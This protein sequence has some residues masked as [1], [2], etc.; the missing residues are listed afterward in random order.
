[1]GTGQQSQCLLRAKIQSRGFN[2][3]NPKQLKSCNSTLK[4]V[5]PIMMLTSSLMEHSS[6]THK[7][8]KYWLKK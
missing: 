6:L 2:N 1:M 3:H 4:Q 5:S 8:V 7:T